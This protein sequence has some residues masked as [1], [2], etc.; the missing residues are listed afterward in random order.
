MSV[1]GE[2]DVSIKSPFGEQVVVLEFANERSGVARYG[3]E[4][5][6]LGNVSTVGDNASWSVALSQPIAVTLKC[7]VT[8]KGDAMSGTASAGFFGKFP[9]TGK[10]RPA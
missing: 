8:L 2:W 4:S 1:V 9:L 7:A 5:L 6:E 3:S 10:R